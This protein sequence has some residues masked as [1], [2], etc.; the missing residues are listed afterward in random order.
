M[1]NHSA[2]HPGVKL[3]HIRAFLDIASEGGLSAVA[4]A[5]GITQPALSRTLAEL[6]T[7]LGQP[8]F[9]RQGRRLV[10][11]E[12]GALFRRHALTA[13]QALEAGAAALRPGSSGTLRIGVLPTVA[14]RFLPQVV[15]R[16]RELHPEILLAAETGP[17]FH[18]MRLLR[19]GLVEVVVGRLPGASEM[20]G[21]SF[22]HLYEDQVILVARADHPLQH[23]T[24]P[25]ALAASP[26]ILPPATALIRPT[27]DDYLAANGLSGIRPALETVS[28]AL[29]RGVCLASDAL[30]FISRGVI[31]H[32]LDRGEMIELPTGARFLSGAVGMTRRQTIAA[33]GLVE[34][35]EI[36]RN[37]AR[38]LP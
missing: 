6:E 8:M 33:P 31:A 17:H 2:I 25:E 24:I 22:D 26:L 1:N 19:D 4:R 10:L 35:E 32:E 23:A 14:T 38:N 3:R 16:F 27:V 29:G 13:M 15:L 21:L 5:Q 36:A 7:L 20:A 11:S 34:F 9:L 30:W 37:V 18:L 12:A 28:L